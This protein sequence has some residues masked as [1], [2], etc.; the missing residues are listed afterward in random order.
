M[1]YPSEE[2]RLAVEQSGY[3][4]TSFEN[5]ITF[6]KRHD[7]KAGVDRFNPYMTVDGRVLLAKEDGPFSVYTYFNTNELDK[8]LA[9]VIGETHINVVIPGQS[10]LAIFVDSKGGIHF[11]TASIGSTGM[12]DKTNPL[13]N[14]ETSAVGRAL[15]LAGYGLIPGTAGVA[16][17]EEVIGA[18]GRESAAAEPWQTCSISELGEEKVSGGGWG[19]DKKFG[20]MTLKQVYEDSDGYGAMEW[21]AG[22][23]DSSG[24]TAMMARYFNLREG[25]AGTGD[26]PMEETLVETD[27]GTGLVVDGM[28]L[29]AG[30]KVCA[31]E[32]LSSKWA[33]WVAKLANQ[34]TGEGKLFGH[35]K[36]LTNHLKKHFEAAKIVD[37]TGRKAAA[38][39]K[40]MQSGGKDKDPE[41]YSDVAEDRE[42]LFGEVD[43][44]EA[45]EKAAPNLP[46][47]IHPPDWLDDMFEAH[48]ISKPLAAKQKE[49]VAKILN[50]IASGTLNV[51]EMEDDDPM[52]GVMI[53]A[54]EKVAENG[55]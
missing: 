8:Q 20:G 39:V 30:K 44:D 50:L 46:L 37:L 15:G 23:T 41:Y 10:C 1:E 35:A 16:S 14:A 24:I 49:A 45:L 13:E 34:N 33:Q 19:K 6:I 22:L 52:R 3:A 4:N 7:K 12:V 17:A 5:H 43:L 26:F 36:H 27:K 40:Y 25:T 42:D 31:D 11:G 21:A 48:G 53:Q 9:A 38:L 2:A 54:F 32:Q 51:R 47:G 18:I 28:I 55:K 29:I